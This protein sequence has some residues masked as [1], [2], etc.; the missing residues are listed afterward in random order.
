MISSRTPSPLAEY[1]TIRDVAR[2]LG[3]SYFSAYA[4]AASGLLGEPLLVGR[5][6][7]YPRAIAEPAIARRRA[8]RR[9]GGRTAPLVDVA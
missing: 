9:R 5:Q 2:E 7:F 6:Y 8:Q 4:L 3:A 1:V